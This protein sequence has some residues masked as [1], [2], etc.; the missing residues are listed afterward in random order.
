MVNRKQYM[1]LNFYFIH[2]YIFATSYCYFLFTSWMAQYFS[3][4]YEK[5]FFS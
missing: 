3:I 2:V 1:N 4:S 5:Q